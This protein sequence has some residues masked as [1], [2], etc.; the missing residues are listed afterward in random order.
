MTVAALDTELPSTCN[1]DSVVCVVFVQLQ[2]SDLF[3]LLANT[4]CGCNGTIWIVGLVP[5]VH[6]E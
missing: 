5:L 3:E 1:N 2:G 4:L 6:L